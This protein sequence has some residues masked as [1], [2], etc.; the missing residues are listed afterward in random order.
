MKY[1]KKLGAR[2]VR[3]GTL[4]L[5]RN[6]FLSGTT[7]L[8]GAL[9][10]FLLNFIFAIQYF[11]DLSLKNLEARADFA[12]P[13]RES[14]E[15]FDIDSLRNDLKNNF[16]VEIK[17][18][19]PENFTNF[20]VPER[21][22][23]KFKDLKQVPGIFETLKSLRYDTVIGDWDGAAERDF[24]TLVEKLL[25]IREAVDKASFWLVIIFIGGGVMLAVNAFRIVL[26]S[27]KQEIF[28]ARLVGADTIFIAGPFLWEGILL[29]IVSAL[30][31]QLIFIFV[32]REI[33]FLP[34]G[35]IFIH[36]WNNIFSAQ[37]I[38]AG[39]VGLTGAWLAIKKYL[40]GNFAN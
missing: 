3:E 18:L 39:L 22:Y 9:V 8:L 33:E 36:L 4:Q 10:V 17:I 1:W 35:D 23:I 14:A 32:L 21:L 20:V 6:K 24:V 15:A 16:D 28:I 7:I 5:W 13:I 34:G 26:F 25:K 29:G 37:I 31:A 11:T 40:T 38:V 30:I 27:R 2:S 12:I 19:P